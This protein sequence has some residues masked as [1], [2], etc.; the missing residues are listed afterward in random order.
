MEIDDIIKDITKSTARYKKPLWETKLIYDSYAETLEPI[1]FWLLDFM[2]GL[3]L[4]VEKITD[5]F[6]ASP[7]SGYFGDISQK[8]STLQDRSMTLL[9]L[10]NDMIKNVMAVIND[11][12][13]R[14]LKLR[15][16][17]D[18]GSE[19]KELK[20]AAILSLKRRWADEVDMKKGRG[21]LLSMNQQAFPGVMDA[22]MICNEEKDVDNLEI[23][24]MI[25]RMLKP[26]VKEWLD[27][28]KKSEEAER[29]YYRIE[30]GHLKAQINNLRLY[31][32]WARPYLKAAEQLRMKETKTPNLVNAFNTMILELSLLGTKEIDPRQEAIDK[33]LPEKFKNIKIERKYHPCIFVDFMFRGIPRAVS[34]GQRGFVHGGRAEVKFRAYALNEDEILMM[35]RKLEEDDMGYILGIAEGISETGLGELKED[36]DK[37]LAENERKKEEEE[38][39]RKI[40]ADINPFAVLGQ[41][42]MDLFGL[43][44]KK[45]W[46]EQEG[47]KADESD[48]EKK[49][50]RIKELEEE[51]IKK[52]SYNESLIRKVAEEKAVETCGKIFEVYKKSHGMASPP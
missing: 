45:G 38:K 48:E 1:Y 2:E 50:E 39:K 41:G 37:F 23:N 10:I 43:G 30:K 31:A 14:E 44:K 36:I 5:N 28:A 11:L 29:K 47:K 13:T 26:R 40:E 51:G 21:S 34:S 35:N 7:G 22:F 6:T 25:K 46:K 42:L 17:D 20:E 52:D 33:I 9:K 3:G 15:D 49:K 16:Y 8:I 4:K 18:S 19:D 27:W 24:D 12:K 32:R